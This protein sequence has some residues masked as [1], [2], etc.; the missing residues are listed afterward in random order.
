MDEVMLDTRISIS[1][2]FLIT[3]VMILV[4]FDYRSQFGHHSY[5]CLGEE[6]RTESCEQL[7]S[8]ESCKSG[9]YELIAQFA[10]MLLAV[11]LKWRRS[12]VIGQSQSVSKVRSF[13]SFRL[14][15]YCR[16]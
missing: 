14:L 6:K 3:I 4:F 7:L 11:R 8:V 9:L 2:E 12:L 16:E 13:C 5:Q 10:V 1:A 15:C